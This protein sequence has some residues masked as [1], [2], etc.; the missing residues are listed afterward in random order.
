MAVYLRAIAYDLPVSVVSNSD[1]ING[2]IG[3]SSDK[4][5][6]KTGIE[7]RHVLGQGET[8][9]D[10]ALT[11][12]KKLFEKFSIGTSEID[13]ILYCTQSPDY[14]L[15]SNACMLQNQLGVPR[16]AG[17]FDFNLGCSGFTYGLWLSQSIIQS[18]NGRNVLLVVGD[19]YS[20]YCE[21]SPLNIKCLFG[22]GVGAAVISKDPIS[23]LADIVHTTVGTDGSGWEQLVVKG[24]AGRSAAYG[25]ERASP[26]YLSMNGPEVFSFALRNT[27]PAIMEL[28]GVIGWSFDSVD[29]FLL[30]QAN[31][32]MIDKLRLSLGVSVDQVPVEISDVGNTVS[33]TL[34][35]L[36]CRSHE[37]GLLISGKRYVLAGFGVGFSW[38]N[39]ALIWR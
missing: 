27:K 10:L 25:P 34:P 15:P 18:G 22:D 9:S 3:W 2:E 4:I 23:A 7:S 14:F 11:V 32:F 30:H 26:A 31:R 28:L 37:K 1:M 6:D 19:A 21:E 24:G 13:V 35:I 33:A 36:I 29:K 16:T 20:R 39:T 8:H 17:C 38:G 5:R 12:C